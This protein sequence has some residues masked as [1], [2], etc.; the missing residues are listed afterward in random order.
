MKKK[1]I[2]CLLLC[3]AGIILVT[4]CSQKSTAQKPSDAAG[5][6][7]ANNGGGQNGNNGQAR[8][9]PDIFGQVKEIS[10]N[11]ITIALAQMPQ[12]VQNQ[13]GQQSQTNSSRKP[14]AGNNGT[15]G[16]KG[17]WTPELTGETKTLAIPDGAKIY[18]GGGSR[19]MQQGQSQGRGP[20]EITLKDVKTGDFISIYYKAGTTTV[21]RVMVRNGGQQQ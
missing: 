17:N 7:N 20:Q 19:S 13:T 21:D 6:V 2:V 14:S 4:G 9:K 5:Q 3:L 1:L 16:Q 12:R 8:Q 10:G 11:N 15:N 18:S